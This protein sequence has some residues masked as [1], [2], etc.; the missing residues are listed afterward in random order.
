MRLGNTLWE[1][2]IAP[3]VYLHLGEERAFRGGNVPQPMDNAD[4]NDILSAAQLDLVHC[5]AL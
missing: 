1:N 3:L 4:D 5:L 2:G